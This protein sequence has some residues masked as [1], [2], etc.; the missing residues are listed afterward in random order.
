[1]RKPI[2]VLIVFLL[3][4]T[5]CS[6]P[7]PTI[8]SEHFTT[9]DLTGFITHDTLGYKGPDPG[10]GVAVELERDQR[11]FNHRREC[12]GKICLNR[13]S[14]CCLYFILGDC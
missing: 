4:F 13:R 10:Y 12:R 2:F 11:D 1:M 6:S 7:P 9:E 14:I 8:E 5:S 3:L